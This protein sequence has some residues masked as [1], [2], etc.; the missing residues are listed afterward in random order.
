M[1]KSKLLL[2]AAISTSAL[3]FSISGAQ[4]AGFYIQEQSVKGLGNAFSGSTTSIDD[5]ST[6]Y[7]NP[8]GMTKLDGMQGNLGV[9]VLVP[10]ADL[11]DNGS[12]AGGN[13][14]DNPYDPTP[15]PNAF[16]AAP[17]ELGG[18]MF[19]AGIGVTAPFG[20]ASEYET[21]DFV[22][23]DS[24]DTELKTINVSPSLAYQVNDMFSIGGGLDIQ[25]ADAE[26]KS[27]VNLGAGGTG[28][29]TLE[30]DDIT[31]GY[32]LGLQYSPT[33]KTDIGFSYR[34]AIS[35]TLEGSVSLE[36]TLANDFD[37]SGQA[38]LDL[39]DITTL[40]I[41]H[42]VNERTRVM[43][44]ATW[45]GW[46]NF[47]T[48]QPIRDDGGAAAETRQNY[49]DTFAIAV[50]IEYDLDDQWTVRGGYQFDETPTTDRFRTS[51][52]PDGDRN[53][54][55]AGATYQLNE[56]MSFDLAGTYIDV[57]EGTINVQRNPVPQTV[58]G[59]TDGYVAIVAG[60]INYKF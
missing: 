43:G 14:P 3:L 53:W 36:G 18:H 7:F 21:T 19:W 49:K 17:V 46:S 48:I 13:D 5:A 24:T 23:L 42:D 47:E 34:S 59:T 12:T 8:A 58:S 37:S 57:D 56:K 27:F 4:A 25:Y 44:Q 41:A 30:G 51:R 50:G 26:L 54:F 10:N 15:I 1:I 40:G 6:V 45:F 39:P 60:A 16:L 9:H 28:I 55:S 22:A 29:S 32:N 20:L 31:V 33:P 52:T 2:T 38:D 11:N 35:H